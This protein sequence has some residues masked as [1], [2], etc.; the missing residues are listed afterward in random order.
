MK[1]TLRLKT[2]P[3]FIVRARN[4]F[5]MAL[6]D[7]CATEELGAANVSV[8]SARGI[9]CSLAFAKADRR[10]GTTAS[11]PLTVLNVV[12]SREMDIG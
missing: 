1:T 11:S 9:E 4:A 5:L 2:H 7:V 8:E 6:K 3:D 10:R 12:F